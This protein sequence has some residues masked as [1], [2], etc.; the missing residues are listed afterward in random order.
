MSNNTPLPHNFS[1]E[2]FS[3]AVKA[4]IASQNEAPYVSL[5]ND[6]CK[7]IKDSKQ[8]D[9]D[10]IRSAKNSMQKILDTERAVYETAV[11]DWAQKLRDAVR[12]A[13]HVQTVEP[14][15]LEGK[16][17]FFDLID[18]I[19]ARAVRVCTFFMYYQNL[20]MLALDP[21]HSL[22]FFLKGVWWNSQK[23]KVQGCQSTA[24]GRW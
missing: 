9:D 17:G 2:V 11:S 5:F 21:I 7:L 8:Y 6:I 24:Q 3:E 13:I 22:T 23:G 14:I 18:G 12:S 15:P 16:D 20:V 10:L 1:R 19:I 4:I